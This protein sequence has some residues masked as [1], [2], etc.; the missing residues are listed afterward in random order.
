MWVLFG[1]YTYFHLFFSNCLQMAFIPF[2][3]ALKNNLGDLHKGELVTSVP[4]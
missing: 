3:K 4:R 2:P 1:F